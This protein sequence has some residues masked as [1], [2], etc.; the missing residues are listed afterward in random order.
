MFF[1]RIAK[2][3]VKCFVGIFYPTKFIGKENMPDK[4]TNCIGICNHLGKIDVVLAVI[5]FKH[6]AYFLGKKE[7]FKNKLLGGFL[8]SVGGI[9]V[10]RENID[11][12]ATKSVLKHIK[13]GDDIMIFPEGTRNKKPQ[14]IELLPLKD[15]A[16]LFALKTK[17]Q[18]VPMAIHHPGRIFRR[19]YFYIGK[20]FT[21]EEFYGMKYT[22]EI[23]AQMDEKMRSAILECKHNLDE[24]VESKYKKK[25]G[26]NK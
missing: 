12:N 1:Y 18:I 15:G 14:E 3:I 22:E 13:N 9:P 21:F 11:I 23:G 19:N 2:V 20:P 17:K 24:I 26:K 7:L 8:K 16:G 4:S 10:D 6:K 5:P 25:N